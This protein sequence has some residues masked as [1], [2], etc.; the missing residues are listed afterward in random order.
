MIYLPFKWLQLKHTPSIC[1]YHELNYKLL[2]VVTSVKKTVIGMF[3]NK[4]RY[5]SQLFTT[6]L[7][8]IAIKIRVK[9]MNRLPLRN[10]LPPNVTDLF[11]SSM[12]TCSQIR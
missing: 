10:L 12:L 5:F 1:R 9:A 3:Q 4:S 6:V 8:S 7:Q 2:H 11:Y